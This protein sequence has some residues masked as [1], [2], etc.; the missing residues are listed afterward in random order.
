MPWVLDGEIAVRKVTQLAL[1]FD[2]RLIDGEL[3][4]RFLADIARV[5]EDPAT[6]L[7]W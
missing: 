7:V 6:A 3:G 5:L 4:S 1:S 2:H